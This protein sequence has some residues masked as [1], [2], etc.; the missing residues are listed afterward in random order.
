MVGLTMMMMSANCGADDDGG[1][2]AL[3]AEGTSL[4]H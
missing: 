2:G 3:V 1:A 4:L